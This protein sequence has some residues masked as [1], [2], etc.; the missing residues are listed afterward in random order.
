MKRNFSIWWLGIKIY[1]G[2]LENSMEFTQK[3]EREQAYD[4]RIPFVDI[5]LKK[6]KI[7]IRKDICTPKF[8][9]GL[10]TVVKILKQ[11]KCSSINI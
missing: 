6:R 3:I 4:T 7:L 11:T 8:I 2:A 1:S 10:F 9:A 5:Y